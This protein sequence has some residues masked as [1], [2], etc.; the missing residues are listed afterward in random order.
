[1][2]LYGPPAHPRGPGG[3]RGQLCRGDGCRLRR[4]AG[5]QAQGP[6]AADEE[7]PEQQEASTPE[8][9]GT[10]IAS[11]PLVQERR[12]IVERGR[13]AHGLCSS[14]WGSPDGP[15]GLGLLCPPAV[16]LG[17]ARG[18]RP[19]FLPRTMEVTWGA[20]GPGVSWCPGH[21]LPTTSVFVKGFNDERCREKMDRGTLERLEIGLFR[22]SWGPV[23]SLSKPR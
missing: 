23:G 21:Y 1:V 15:P 18:A 22:P 3:P 7:E 5:R 6:P 16:H 10:V 17:A 13:G 9:L 20:V 12:D 2:G 8:P 14:R 19:L 11:A 4:G